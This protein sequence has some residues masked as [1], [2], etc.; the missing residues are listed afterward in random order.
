LVTIPGAQL[1]YLNTT[2]GEAEQLAWWGN[3]GDGI[4]SLDHSLGL[5][6]KLD[7]SKLTAYCEATDGWLYL[8]GADD[9]A[10][11]RKRLGGAYHK[12]VWDEAQKIPPK[13]TTPIREVFMPAMLDF[14]GRFRLTG[15]PSRQMSGLFY[16]VT[17]PDVARRLPGWNV[18]HWNLLSNVYF[19]RDHDER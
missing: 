12:V 14:G 13:L 1:L 19:G 17:R 10:E 11:L 16:E 18:H 15:S 3:R 7:N 5:G 6:L 4:A 9:E 8:R 2:R